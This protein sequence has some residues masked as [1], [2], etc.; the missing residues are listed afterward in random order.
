MTGANRSGGVVKE[1]SSQLAVGRR[2]DE[3]GPAD[4]GLAAAGD[5]LLSD[6]LQVFEALGRVREDV[7]GVLQRQRADLGQPAPDLG[8]K[9]EGRGGS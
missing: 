8:P 2:A 1:S 5:R 6:P 4:D 7:D 9:V 3:L